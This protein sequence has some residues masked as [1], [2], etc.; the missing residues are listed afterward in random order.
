MIGFARVSAGLLAVIAAATAPLASGQERP[1]L[2]RD[3]FP[4]GAGGEILC[5]VQD[6]SISNPARLTMFDR[7]WAVVCRDSA[8]PVATIYAF[9]RT[10]G[11]AVG[12][13]PVALI[14]PHRREPVSCTAAATASAAIAGAQARVCQVTGTELA[15]SLV[16]LDRGDTTYL[17]EGFA[18]YDSATMLALKSI[19]ANRIV[20]GE[21]TIATT[22]ITDSLSFARIQ[23]Q[24]L[25]PGQALAEGYRRNLGGEYAEASAYFE[26]LQDRLSGDEDSGV[27][28]GEFLVNR[29]LQKSNLG[30]FAEADRLFIE[31]AELTA[32]D[33][34][35][36]RLQRN[37]EAIHFLNQNAPE[38][39]VQRLDRK[40]AMTLPDAQALIERLE[41]SIP[42]SS[43]LNSAQGDGSLLGYVDE[44]KLS[45]M[46]RAQII[47]AQ[48][49]QLLGTALRLEGRNDEARTALL[50]AWSQAV[51]VRDGRVTSIARLRAQV[52]GELSAIAES[53]GDIGDATLYLRNAVDILEAQYPE[54]KA[55]AGA[56]ARLAALLLRS[57]GEDEANTIYHE[58]IARAVGR[59]NAATGFANQLAPYFQYLAERVESDPEAAADFFAATQVLVRP[60][61]AE[62][63]AILARELSARS[64][65]AS[66]L[67]RQSNDLSRDIE[68][69]RIRAI[70]LGKIEQ[71][72]DLKLVR[73]NLAD[74]IA[75]LESEQLQTQAR[76]AQFPEYRVVAPRSLA[77]EDFRKTLGP[78]EAYVRLAMVAGRPF[79]FFADSEGAK[80]YRLDLDEE[81]L[82]LKVDLLRYSISA[83]ED[84]Q[85]LTYPYDIEAARELYVSLF[86]P[87]ADRLAK[88]Q[89]LVFEPDG[90]M[91]RLPIDILVA[92][93]A[94]VAKY[95]AR[96]AVSG[97]DPYDFTGVNWLARD[98]RVSTAVSAQAF[99]DA[100]ASS[101]SAAT[102]EYLG[103][104]DNTPV[105]SAPSPAIQAM[106]EG[107]A[108]RCHWTA[109]EW[110]RP[111]D[112]AEL[113]VARGIVG[114]GRSRII[115]GAEFTDQ[116]I[117][118]MDDIADYRVLHFATHG[119]VT[120]P[121][122]PCPSRP[123]LL[124]S[125]G[126]EGSDGL[127]SFREIFDL[128]LDADLVILSACDTAGKA[129]I[130]ATRDAGVGSG[131]GTA[132]DGLVRSFIGAGGRSV[133]ASHWPAPDEYDATQ[134]LMNG[135]FRA[136]EAK[137]VGQ[138]LRESQ[139]ALMDQAIT[140]HPFYWGGFAIIGDAERMLLAKSTATAAVEAAGTLALAQVG[141]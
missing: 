34:I 135:M 69:R 32:Q 57:G 15:W 141:E 56:K 63:Q 18:A 101:P 103:F 1:V 54:R 68:R 88:V 96:S 98:L 78:G 73:A 76:L 58:V 42:I 47:D 123:A 72:G 37:F 127:L 65:E 99:V 106:L 118:A 93:D 14:A 16:Q 139:F 4:I 38:A 94:S 61:V 97:S 62:T 71:T 33:P 121:A 3:S 44:L 112:P 51:A 52:L 83:Y 29:A 53:R 45:E 6:R 19:L 136:G 132:L 79:V 22:S 120:P 95:Q 46:E 102:R 133:M 17:A 70:A 128:N 90:A 10:R 30:D 59:T 100:R 2:L 114:E 67:F 39:A 86:G 104:G 11:A 140:S 50:D 130:E 74:E 13:D 28:A 27:D 119:L 75:V 36:A 89:H 122:P 107:G 124:T 9:D 26:T 25:E 84:G 8:S 41:I 125:F 81:E 77:L 55:Q 111:I 85:Y 48:A 20:E 31:A 12:A 66:R 43:R 82:D 60:G 109:A 7:A 108:E 131:G 21:V 24:T 126:G 110:N 116:Q 129:S 134:R 23:A 80:A 105:G 35:T 64:D 115:T 5:Q 113:N 92:D 138:A 137:P 91:L 117:V 40:L 87:V 49:L